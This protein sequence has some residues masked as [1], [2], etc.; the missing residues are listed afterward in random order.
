MP[1][2][3]I[4]ILLGWTLHA[5]AQPSESARR[6]FTVIRNG[7]ADKL[8]QLLNTDAN[9]NDSLDGY[10]ALMIAAI[11]G[12]AQEMRMLIQHGANVNFFN[13]DSLTALWLA[14]PDRDKAEL[15]LDKGADIHLIAKDGTTILSKLS[16]IA[17]S[18]PL[19]Q[20]FIDKGANLQKSN[21]GNNL[22]IRSAISGDTAILGLFIRMGLEVNGVDENGIPP[23]IIAAHY[24]CIPTLSML[25][26]HGANINAVS[27]RRGMTAL[28]NAARAGDEDVVAFLL[29]RGADAKIVSKSGY[30]ALTYWGFSE[31]DRPDSTQSMYDQLGKAAFNKANDGA[32]ALYWSEKRGQ[33]MAV[34]L[35]KKYMQQ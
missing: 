4:T 22:I 11:S 15:L 28:M 35:L 5:Y 25:L 1:R 32:D 31:S 26:D 14:I 34:Q 16:S 2:I 23:L 18:A 8:E 10:S 20:L 33:T 6:L 27:Q 21:A 30:T 13:R 19:I 29:E 24:H 9:P 17:G 12:T 3:L 7:E